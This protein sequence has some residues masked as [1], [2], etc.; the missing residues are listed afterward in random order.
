MPPQVVT[1]MSLPCNEPLLFHDE[2]RGYRPL[3]RGQALLFPRLFLQLSTLEGAAF[4]ENFP[5]ISEG[6]RSSVSE[7]FHDRARHFIEWRSH[8]P[9]RRNAQKR[10][11]LFHRKR[12]LPCLLP[13]KGHHRNSEP[14]LSLSSLPLSVATLPAFPGR[15]PRQDRP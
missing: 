2:E 4:Q 13:K 6:R 7:L 15:M 3:H 12:Y 9:Y 10:T 14:L 5:G 8:G 1:V 11:L